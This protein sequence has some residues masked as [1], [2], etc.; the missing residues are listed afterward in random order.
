LFKKF[1][2]KLENFVTKLV[3]KEVC[4]IICKKIN[5]LKK[6]KENKE[7]SILI[8]TM[9]AL[10][11]ALSIAIAMSS[12]SIVERKM[13]TKSR[14]SVTAFQSANSGIEWAMKEI[15]DAGPKETIQEV[16]GQP[17]SNGEVDCPEDLFSNGSKLACKIT[18]LKKTVNNREPVDNNDGN[19][20][21]EDIVAIRSLGSF[22]KAEEQ[23]GRA[24]EAYAMPNCAS[25]EIRVA[26]FC[27]E[28]DS[29]SGEDW[30]EAIGTC[31]GKGKRLCTAA[32]LVAA[33]RGGIS[34]DL[35]D[36]GNYIMVDEGNQELSVEGV[37]DSNDFRCCRNR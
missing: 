9:L 16:F 35:S 24:L 2:S 13:T 11:G 22:G 17:S 7:G 21:V 15:N 12:I 30:K 10:V 4:L 3:S 25:D 34:A 36:Q 32:E 14:K 19:L 31:E 20:L 33:G 5:M 26:D 6:M 18:L 28:E 23:V 8:L 1:Y 27:V 29:N 37:D